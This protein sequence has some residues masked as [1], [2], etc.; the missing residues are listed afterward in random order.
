MNNPSIGTVVEKV[1]AGAY[2]DLVV[3]VF[4]ADVFHDPMT[5]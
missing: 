3:A 5:P 4:G 2:A 1:E